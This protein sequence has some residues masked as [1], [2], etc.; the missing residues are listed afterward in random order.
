MS[1]TEFPSHIPCEEQD[2]TIFD[3]YG[4]RQQKYPIN[5]LDMDTRLLDAAAALDEK[6]FKSLRAAASYFDVKTTT[7]HD[8][9]HGAV[10]RQKAR[11]SQQY[12]TPYDELALCE[13][14]D[15]NDARE[16]VREARC[17]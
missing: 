13:D 3:P 10:S 14:L 15:E 17:I 6:R 1:L 2:P 11:Q 5:E 12:L 9:M 8:R 16:G 4:L 7:L